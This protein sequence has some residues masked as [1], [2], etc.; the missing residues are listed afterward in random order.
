MQRLAG[1]KFKILKGTDSNL[2]GETNTEI[3]PTASS[4]GITPIRSLGNADKSRDF[5]LKKG[6]GDLDVLRNAPLF[7]DPRYTSSTLSI[8]TDNRTL[9]GLYRFFAETDPIVG[10]ALKLHTELPLADVG[11]G[12]CEDSG[13]QR[14]FEIMWDNLNGV[15]LLTDI[16][17][18]FYEIGD[19]FPFGAFNET[20]YMWDQF[21]ILNPD[22]VKVDSTWVNQR[23]LIKLI[24]DENLKR[25]VQTRSPKFIYEQLPPEIVRYVLFSRE[26]PLD[27]NNVFHLSH[28]KRPYE[29]RGKS[30]IKRILKVLMLEDRFNQANF[31]L[32]T[33]HAVPLTV[34]KVG[35]PQSIEEG[36]YVTYLQDDQLKIQTFKDMWN[37]FDG[38]VIETEGDK[39]AKDIRKYNL[40]T[41]SLGERGEKSWNRIEYILRH[42][43]PEEMVEVNTSYSSIRSTTSHG[44]MW[45]NPNTLAYEKVSPKQLIKRDNPTLV[46]FDKFDFSVEADKMF[47]E[48]LTSKLSYFLGIWTADGNFNSSQGNILKISNS[49]FGVISYL[50][51]LKNFGDKTPYYKSYIND[52]VISITHRKLKDA[53]LF[54]Y[55][56]H[57]KDKSVIKT[58]KEKIPQEIV[59]NNN[60]KIVG[61][62]FAG[63]FDGDGYITSDLNRIIISTGASKEYHHWLSLALLARGIESKILY[64]GKFSKKGNGAW[65]LTIRG[66]E[67]ILRCIKLI[68][69]YVQHSNKKVLIQKLEDRQKKVRTSKWNSD[70]YDVSD[71]LREYLLED[72]DE[73]VGNG[74]IPL[75]YFRKYSRTIPKALLKCV[76][77]CP[78]KEI[79]QN[80][81]TVSVNKI[82]SIKS[83]SEFVYDLMLEKNPHTYIAAGEGWCNTRNTGWIPNDEELNDVRTLFAAWELD[84][85]F[86]IFYHYGI[87]VE[88][89]GSNGKMLPIGPE[90][91]RIYRLKFIGLQV[92][93]QLLAG[94]GGSYSQ[95]Y[96]N[97]EV[98]RQRYL[99]LQLRLEK[100]LHV[101]IFKPVADLCGFYKIHKTTSGPIG[102]SSKVYGGEDN[103]KKELLS[104]FTSLRDGQD[105]EEFQKFIEHKTA[106]YDK[107]SSQQERDY[108]Y[109]EIDWGAMSAATDE[110]LKNYIKWLVKERP[111]LV[112][113]ATLARL[114]KLDRDTQEDVYFKDLKREADRIKRLSEEG[115]LE[116]AQSRGKK[117]GG[118]GAGFAGDIP[119][120]G[121]DMGGL[122]TGGGEG[123]FAGEEPEAPV[124]AGGPPAAATEGGPPAGIEASIYKSVSDDDN[125]IV[126]ENE[127]LLKQRSSYKRAIEKVIIDDNT[128]VE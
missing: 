105:N 50:T 121:G 18:E 6:S 128:T 123:M 65:E 88:F 84:P 27:P 23:P 87:N 119:I 100:F 4:S 62:Y 57:P 53:L 46:T 9:H 22:Y 73:R 126:Q 48:K 120:G 67:N 124:G 107:L 5:L 2:K 82:T 33:R 39:E 102:S 78:E 3:I 110:N 56:Y 34:V 104:Q 117:G 113:D 47:G 40:Y 1:S 7:N 55:G 60:D 30:I 14:H 69:K 42:K 10:A 64:K 90:L 61:S 15:K 85:N 71:S 92:H 11:L 109:P 111:Y 59:F 75:N 51:S 63:V 98:Q 31:A 86:S 83:K 97:L 103:F 80:T 28:A 45:L 77:E 20:T 21:T 54:Y 66:K 125:Y 25:I 16:V 41:Q 115:L 70:K 35:D 108:I 96:I 72:T 19:V 13:V 12:Q 93:E 74:L 29:L 95:A 99:N 112:D 122:P 116:L 38:R 43:T 58:G 79:L 37:T 114:G 101:G 89:Y 81:H 32:A 36:H 52:T 91:E 44:F 127:V 68:K 17:A 24:P 8:P 49:D 94:G 106:E 26:I 118:A 76:K